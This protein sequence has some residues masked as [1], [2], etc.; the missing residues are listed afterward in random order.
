MSNTVI[1][2]R[3]I[4]IG[5]SRGIRIPQLMLDQVGL[6]E[7]VELAVQDNQILIRPAAAP[8]QGWDEQFKAMAAAGDDHLLDADSLPENT[9]DRDEWE[10]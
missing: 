4:K 9:W 1:K 3:I 7:V 10:W 6:G 8:R 2:A 5:N